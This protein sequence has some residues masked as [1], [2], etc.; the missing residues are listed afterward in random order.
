MWET[1]WSIISSLSG[2]ITNNP[3]VT[4]CFAAILYISIYKAG[5]Y[6]HKTALLLEETNTLLRTIANNTQKENDE[7]APRVHRLGDLPKL[8]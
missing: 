7:G 6:A 5:R 4:L 2:I 3:V 1:M 8:K